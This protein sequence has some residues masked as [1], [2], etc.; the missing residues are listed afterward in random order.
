MSEG[1]DKVVK[2]AFWR[3][4]GDKAVETLKS[5]LH[6]ELSDEELLTLPDIDC[7][8]VEELVNPDED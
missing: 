3:I 8:D 6:P 5:K 2:Q 1:M 4:Y 7:D